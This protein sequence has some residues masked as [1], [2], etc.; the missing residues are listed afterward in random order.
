MRPPTSLLRP[1]PAARRAVARLAMLALL[2]AAL[3]PGVSRLLQGG[4]AWAALCRSAPVALAAD[5]SGAAPQPPDREHGDACPLCTLAHTTPVLAGA[6]ALAP[7]LLA[8]VPPAPRLPAPLPRHDAQSR[9]PAAR[10]PPTGAA[11]SAA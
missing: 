4:E 6:A 7:G 8:Y 2:A 11:I 9:P 5:H 1:L 3:L 10:G